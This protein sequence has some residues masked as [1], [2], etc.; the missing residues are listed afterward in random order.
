MEDSQPERPAPTL[1]RR[2][3]PEACERCRRRRTKCDGLNPC[4]QCSRQG[5]EC[6]FASRD[7]A[8]NNT[9]L[10][11]KFDLILSRLDQIETTLAQ[12][13]KDTSCK[14]GDDWVAQGQ[15][16]AIPC[17][18][19][20]NQQTGCFEFYGSTSTFVFAN[21]LG[22]QLRQFKEELSPLR[23]ERLRQT[24]HRESMQP[25]DTAENLD[26]SKLLG[27]CDYVVPYNGAFQQ[28]A[29][30]KDVA[31]R[32]VANFFQTIY[33][34]L[35]VFRVQRFRKRYE[36]LREL[37]GDNAGFLTPRLTSDRQQSLCL[38]Y[39]VLA[40]GALYE[41]GR[42]DSSTWA[43]Y[44]FGEAQNI[45]GRLLDA[46]NIELVQ[47][48]LLMG[49]YAQH[50][51]NP[52]LAY[53]LVGISTRF[54]FSIGLNLDRYHRSL[55]IDAEEAK[56]T[57]CLLYVQ[58]IELSLDSGRPMSFQKQ[59]D[60]NFLTTKGNLPTDRLDI[61]ATNFVHHLVEIA[62]ILERI[63]K[64]QDRSLQGAQTS[65]EKIVED[66]HAWRSALPDYLRF[67]DYP[68]RDDE[69]QYPPCSAESRQRSS[70]RIHYNLAII[71]L[72]RRW[73]VKFDKIPPK[74][75]FDLY[76]T[77]CLNASADM[78]SYIHRIFELAPSVRKWSYYCYYCLQAMLP[79]LA[80]IINE[81]KG[82]NTEDLVH[83][84]SL[85]VQV[86]KQIN[87]KAAE[88]CA[89]ISCRVLDYWR[90]QK[91]SAN[92][93]PSYDQ[94]EA[95]ENTNRVRESHT[96]SIHTFV[97]TG[98]LASSIL[99][100]SLSMSQDGQEQFESFPDEQFNSFFDFQ[101]SNQLIEELMR[102]PG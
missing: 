102:L 96:D 68:G 53:N 71:I 64:L 24:F 47:A 91:Q 88:R 31:D 6:I 54:A 10:T 8:S 39:A 2:K 73:V 49:A 36:E 59:P 78:I 100:P 4:K 40:L 11:S 77:L 81:P 86:F 83:I 69:L 45:L 67:E 60:T 92:E 97:E 21:S 43:A 34:F 84:C 90:S 48:A 37:L 5:H 20:L 23:L 17:V 38:I 18:T 16:I 52:N 57:W 75:N 29:L 41:Y 99:P 19:E 56:R 74:S 58:E 25:K 7:A 65:H 79:I 33:F 82:E 32:H 9:I 35:P 1:S 13:I 72:N 70:M 93:E 30:S 94:E 44:Y 95:A 63:I 87:L 101:S 50:V 26:L 61:L 55:D 42:D 98:D 66:L 28:K 80:K 76:Q 62:K 51:I 89:E 14:S 27:S 85:G 3:T 46:V 12:H 22:K 15:S